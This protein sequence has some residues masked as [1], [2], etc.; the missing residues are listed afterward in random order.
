MNPPT[1]PTSAKACCAA[2]YGSD[3][4]AVLLGDSYHPGGMALTRRLADRLAVRPGEVVLDVAG[5]RGTTALLLAGE[6]H[7]DV[8]G[9]DLSTA[10][11]A[12]ATDAAGRAGLADRIRFRLGDAERLPV[13]D[14]AFD[15][16]VCECA[17]CVFPDK[18]SA[19][20][21]LARILRPGGRLGITD[22]TVDPRRLPAEL[23]GLGGWIACVADARPLDEYAGILTRAGLRVAV[24]ERHDAVIAAMLDQ[25]DA[26]LT[27]VRMTARDRAE[28]AGL[29]F[30]RAR[31][32]LAAARTAVTGG[33]IGYGLLVAARS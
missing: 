9:I 22:V 20:A 14:G 4:V 23:A 1:A 11:V 7:T 13:P 27:M 28:A 31:A 26:R 16:A 24:R 29:D 33:V 3:L 30:D 8:T 18:A 2:A 21:E 17:F 6:Y 32:V 19:A 25:I 10:N 12:A 15:V 5:G